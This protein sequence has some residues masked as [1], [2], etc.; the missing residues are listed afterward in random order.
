MDSLFF[1]K[2]RRADFRSM[3]RKA[4]GRPRVVI[5]LVV[6]TALLMVVLFGSRGVVQRL[7]L[8]GEKTA[9]EEKIHAA[10]AEGRRL[11]AEL[12]ALE[13]DGKAI[14]KVARE[15]W[16]MIRKGETVY[17]VRRAER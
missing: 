8:M 3:L 15:K 9:L 13:G 17:R 16:G 14:E 10:E 12:K 1:R 2:E 11:Q 4:L 7:R 5:A 6:G